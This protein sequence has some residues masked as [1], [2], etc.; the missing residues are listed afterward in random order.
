MAEKPVVARTISLDEKKTWKQRLLKWEVLL[1]ILLIGIN[2]L[3]SLLSKNYLNLQN[4]SNTL[5]IFLDKGIVAF[6]VMMV[7]LS[8]PWP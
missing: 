6:P 8:G 3:N 4:L 1:F 7:M 2:V 5:K